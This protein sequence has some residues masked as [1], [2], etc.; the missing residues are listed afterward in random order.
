MAKIDFGNTWWGKEWLSALEKIDNENR[1][2]RGKT[3]ARK[4][5]V[6]EIN[7]ETGKIISRV[8]GNQKK[9]YQIIIKLKH[10]EEEE[11]TLITETI[12][13]NP[14]FISKMLS[15]IMPSEL[16]EYLLT[17][18][19]KIFPDK[20]KDF[21]TV[22]SCP[23][24]AV[25]CKHI[26]AVIYIIANEIDK[27]P[28]ILFELRNYNIKEEL[29]KTGFQIKKD[30]KDEIVSIEKLISKK[31]IKIN[32]EKTDL[33][34]EIIDE[35]DFS[36]I[37]DIHELTFSL[38]N[39]NPLF[40]LKD[41]F[42]EIMKSV[43]KNVKKEIENSVFEESEHL[44]PEEF[45]KL[46]LVFN[47]NME[48]KKAVL[49]SRNEKI[50]FRNDPDKIISF[51]SKIKSARVKDLSPELVSLYMIYHLSIKLI[52]TG[53]F[54]PEL[55]KLNENKFIIRWIPVITNNEINSIFLK[56][57]SITQNDLLSIEKHDIEKENP[58]YI[59]ISR[60]EQVLFILNI[61]LSHFIKTFSKKN[62]VSDEITDLFF[63]EKKFVL[64]SF[65]DNEI[66]ANISL[67]LSKF[68]L[69]HKDFSP[70][71]KIT[72]H[73]SVFDIE[74]LIENK[75][76]PDSHIK[77]DDFLNKPEYEKFKNIILKDLSI[78]SEYF[79]DY[80]KVISSSGKDKLIMDSQNFTK[81]FFNVLPTMKL[82][83]VKILFPKELKNLVIPKLNIYMKKT[84]AYKSNISYLTLKDM[85]T[86]DWTVSVGNENLS[87]S[88]FLEQV[89]GMSGIVKIKENF[90]LIDENE[91][92]RIMK[93]MAKPPKMTIEDILKSSLTE[94]YEDYKLVINEET[95]SIIKN[96]FNLEE[97][98][99]PEGFNAT[100]REY[101]M[102]GYRW[103]Y[104]NTRVGFGSIIADD[105]GLGKTIQVITL[106]LKLKEDHI[107]GEKKAL[108][109]VPTTLITNW[110]KEINRFAP[111]LKIFIYHGH[112]RKL[113]I[114]ECDI[115]ITTYGIIRS[116]AGKFE[117]LDWALI[118]IDEAQNIKN[119]VTDQTKAVKK[120]NSNIKIAM[121][122]TPVE[123]SLI[124]YWSIF[125]FINKGYLG[126]LK[127]F[128]EK[129]A[130][131]IE[132]D[133]EKEKLDTFKKITSPF[134]MRRVKTDKSIIK[135]LPEKIE[136]E[137][138]S[139]LTKVQASLY[140]NMLDTCMEKIEH[141]EGIF[142]RGLVLKL[143]TS[144]KQ[145]CNHPSQFLKKDDI[146]PELSG[147][148]VILL[149][150]L[151]D[152]Y[153]HEEKVLIF[154]QY[155]QMG[156][157]LKKMI[158]HKI[159][160]EVL[161]LHGSLE[162]NKRDELVETFSNEKYIKTMIL[163]LKA[164]GTGLNLV[165]ANH[166]IHFDLWWNPAVEAQATDRAYRIGQN[167]N[168]MVNRFIT[169][170]TFE[171]KIN[172][173]IK[174]KRELADLAVSNGEQWIGEMDNTELRNIFELK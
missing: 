115:V 152:I 60:N 84:S 58:E 111:A 30:S 1:L 153:E 70:I 168:V 33:F 61:F 25:P 94:E 96:L 123:N 122:G 51:L 16:N 21:Q 124:E 15:G 34:S 170:G 88:E 24:Y 138:F 59:T 4:G 140:Q 71:L 12:S 36:A 40:Y 156:E 6:L 155:K 143:M 80:D 136:I 89:H 169:T 141:S 103:L 31:D 154:T 98:G 172:D 162:R 27:N 63:N 50:N 9:P 133:R 95:S 75:N 67:W 151:E 39:K 18:K 139:N 114:E 117:K 19:I 158:E 81:I 164:G 101:Q 108:V 90:I 109:V 137:R 105:M 125:D 130:I 159:K 113:D 44:Y 43:Y 17:K 132:K 99:L 166:V 102:R 13:S 165:S 38:L 121:S 173:M 167:K 69:Q 49:S 91:I 72:D 144:L 52:Q 74:T 148:T 85:I 128:Y 54:I 53:G 73:E 112:K 57:V 55:I 66:P 77:L 129:F 135:D 10:F 11:K 79:P 118:V 97:I 147:K 87:C 134:I 82:L 56:I 76:N 146:S 37:K 47:M 32:F 163:S 5:A 35:I 14:F 142:R 2:P 86:F 64:K 127:S 65:S 42:R 131:P 29:N 83:G 106:L 28:F 104:K 120:L 20:W 48:L 78:L 161:F 45:R 119:P 62:I 26:A 100:L 8:Q 116:E 126:S 110:E 160:S 46:E 93:V 157:L 3:Y 7:F 23:D 68:Y 174:S 41:D 150:L 92:N 107:I 149:D 22:C 171:E 145:I